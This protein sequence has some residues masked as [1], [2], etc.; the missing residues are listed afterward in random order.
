MKKPLSFHLGQ[1]HPRK[2]AFAPPTPSAAR[3][4]PDPCELLSPNFEVCSC[5]LDSFPR[6]RVTFG[7]APAQPS[8]VWLVS[9]L[10]TARVRRAGLPGVRA[11]P[12]SDS[13]APC[14]HINPIST[15]ACSSS[16]RA[17]SRA[18]LRRLLQCAAGHG[19][20]STA[21]RFR[22]SDRCS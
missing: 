9:M 6:H 13:P 12:A 16:L 14:P 18:A 2:S 20:S 21:T 22:R 8:S 4:R 15:R 1:A 10:D 11:A 7:P 5:P 3:F 19:Q 17:V